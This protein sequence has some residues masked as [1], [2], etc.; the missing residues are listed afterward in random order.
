[1]K[2]KNIILIAILLSVFNLLPAIN[3]PNPTGWVNDYAKILNTSTKDELTSIITELKHLT[4]VDIAVAIVNDLQGQDRDS[5]ANE[6]YSKWK[7]GN[8]NDE[9][10]LILLAIEDRE[11]KVEVGY[12][13]EAYLTDGMVGQI[14]DQ[15][16]IPH[17]SKNDYS[18]GIRQSVIVFASYIAQKKG[19]QLTGVKYHHVE[20]ENIVG[21]MIFLGFFIF[22]VI[23]TRGRILIWLLILGSG[24]RGGSGGFGGRGGSGGFGGFGG[25][26]GGS[27][28]GGGAGRRF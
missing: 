10:I 27:S 13:S 26:G 8:N 16:V 22:L 1:M 18:E 9:G 17:L 12:G 6:L 21:K 11:F 7:I 20:S 23:V 19:V 4:N 28:G 5:Y 3:Y 14:I 25:F 2:F 24:G 15:Y